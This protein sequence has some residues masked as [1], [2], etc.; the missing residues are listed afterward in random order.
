MW[1]PG[2]DRGGRGCGKSQLQAGSRGHVCQ[3]EW[4]EWAGT[5]G[6]SEASLCSARVLYAGEQVGAHSSLLPCVK[7]KAEGSGCGGIRP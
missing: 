7:W 1:G 2:E 5:V 6:C 3:G 4:Q